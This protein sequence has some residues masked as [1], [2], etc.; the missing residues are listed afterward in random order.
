MG[1]IPSERRTKLERRMVGRR[2]RGIRRGVSI[3][4][5][6]FLR[7]ILLHD[8]HSFLSAMWD[9]TQNFEAVIDLYETIMGFA[10][11]I[12]P[13]LM[14]KKKEKEKP[15][16]KENIAGGGSVFSQISMDEDNGGPKCLT[17]SVELLL[18]LNRWKPTVSSFDTPIHYS[19]HT[20]IISRNQ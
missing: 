6:I 3:K 13:S 17:T 11:D 2:G 20:W 14:A 18:S 10:E 9:L 8:T 4:R 19:P 15:T 7:H 16:V 12:T 5:A 1:V